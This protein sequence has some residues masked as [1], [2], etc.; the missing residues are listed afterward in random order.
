EEA[1]RKSDIILTGGTPRAKV[2]AWSGFTEVDQFNLETENRA[3][4][5]SRRLD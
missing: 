5:S 3:L 1:A 2:A 4:G